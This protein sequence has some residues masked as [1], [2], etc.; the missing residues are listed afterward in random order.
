MTNRPLDDRDMAL[1]DLLRVDAREPVASLARKVGL[2]RSAVQE[3]LARL[4]RDAVIQGYE[5][6][7]S[8]DP[9]KDYV[10]AH[11]LMA[12][13]QKHGERVVSAL[14]AMSEVRACL[15]VSGSHDLI[16]IVMAPTM[17]ELDAVLDRIAALPAVERTTSSLVL[18]VKFDRR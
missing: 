3:R 14:R 17:E 5:V 9:F 7:L 2:S 18:S 15:A 11:V 10:T 8:D 4:E 6:R 13:D 16:A 1:I 12:L